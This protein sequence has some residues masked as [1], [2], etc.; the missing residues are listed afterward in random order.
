[1]PLLAPHTPPP[2]PQA[3]EFSRKLSQTNGLPDFAPDDNDGDQMVLFSGPPND[4]FLDVHN[5]NSAEV[6]TRNGF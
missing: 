5:F 1:V 4:M 2:A 3:V 6:R